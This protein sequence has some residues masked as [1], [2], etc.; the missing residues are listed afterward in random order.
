LS[1]FDLEIHESHAADVHTI[2]MSSASP[3]EQ[4]GNKSGESAYGSGQ[5]DSAKSPLSAS[6]GFL[7]SLTEKKTTRGKSGLSRLQF[8]A[9]SGVS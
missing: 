6:L 5:S 1:P 9:D 2:A 8:I 3:I 4:Y 7:K